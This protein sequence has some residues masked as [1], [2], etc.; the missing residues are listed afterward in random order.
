[1]DFRWTEPQQ[2]LRAEIREFLAE[3][4]VGERPAVAPMTDPDHEQ[5]RE[6]V[7][8][9]AGAGWMAPAWPKE[10]GGLGLGH[11]ERA[12]FA[13]EF[14]MAGAPEGARGPG[15][16]ML[17][18]IL[19]RHGTEEQRERF[20]GG[21][22]SAHMFWCQ[23]F[24]EPGSG[25]DL[26][27]LSTTAKRDGDGYVIN[28]QKIWTSYA[29]SADWC[30]LLARTDGDAPKHKGISFFVLPMSSPGIRV[31]P[32]TTMLEQD[33]FAEVFFDDVFVPRENL[34]GEENRGWYVATD[35]LNFERAATGSSALALR[36]LDSYAALMRERGTPSPV[37][38]QEFA[39]LYVRATTAR[40]LAYRL[41]WMLD[42]GQVP[43][44]LASEVKL[45]VTEL[46][47]RMAGLALRILGNEAQL[48][49]GPL[50]YAAINQMR[51]V[52]LTIAGG[53]SEIQRNLIAKRRL[54]LS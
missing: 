18:P 3:N 1:M 25:S 17:G 27:S 26:A 9:L 54:G 28:G 15:I 40:L 43:G 4:L 16:N 5:A 46:L 36:V 21:I 7:R 20:L 31:R 47:Q 45:L 35:L 50:R 12:I 19:I 38:R 2:A 51:T 33:F 52:A 49:T 30:F 23:G 41:A 24:S 8:R 13:E 11:I 14:A 32:L 44:A 34:V 29:M 48:L 42:E 39:D 53:T 37:V 10:Y 22:V 6:F